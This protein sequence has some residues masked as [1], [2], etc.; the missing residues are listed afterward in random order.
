[1][2]GHGFTRRAGINEEEKFEYQMIQVQNRG[3]SRIQFWS[4]LNLDFDI[5]SARPGAM[6]I[7]HRV[8]RQPCDCARD[9]R[10]KGGS[11]Q[12]AGAEP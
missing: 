4:F 7:G 8:R 12:V 10:D 2:E 9:R 3:L 6:V 11:W 5:V 1:M